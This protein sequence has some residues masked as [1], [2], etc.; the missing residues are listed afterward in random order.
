MYSSVCHLQF[1]IER[2][3]WQITANC[4]SLKDF[5]QALIIFSVLRHIDVLVQERRYSI[6][7]ALELRPFAPIHRYIAY[8]KTTREINPS[9]STQLVQFRARYK[10][11]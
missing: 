7:N 5:Y 10:S 8:K 4:I 1:D 3:A 11:S 6:V 9:S 2:I